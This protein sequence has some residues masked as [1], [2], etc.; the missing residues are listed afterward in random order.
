MWDKI[1]SGEVC[2]AATGDEKKRGGTNGGLCGAKTWL[3]LGGARLQARDF[4]GATECA[5]KG[6]D[7]LG[8]GYTSP[9]AVDDTGMAILMAKYQISQGNASQGAES[10]LD[11]LAERIASYERLHGEDAGIHEE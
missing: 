3:N 7:E 6:L 2:V 4:E 1:M 9:E 10:L 8:K 11:I 5:Q